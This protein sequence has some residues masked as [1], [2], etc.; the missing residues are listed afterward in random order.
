MPD[1]KKNMVSGVHYGFVD[2]NN[3]NYFNYFMNRIYDNAEEILKSNTTD[4]W[5]AQVVTGLKYP[6][7]SNSRKGQFSRARKVDL[8]D[9]ISRYTVKIRIIS[10]IYFNDETPS[11]TEMLP[12]HDLSGLSV[13]ESEYYISLYPDA[14]TENTDTEYPNYGSYCLVRDFGGQYFIE[15]LINSGRGRAGSGIGRGRGGPG[16]Q[17]R[18]IPGFVPR[19][20]SVSPSGHT[21]S[22]GAR[23]IMDKYPGL[24]PSC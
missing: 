24:K 13:D 12:Q 7:G 20:S 1:Y 4:F 19:G 11:W 6:H 9:G 17:H 8:G 10:S 23:A 2:G 16:T 22:P 18:N 3:L 5:I 14:Y 15:R 21:Y